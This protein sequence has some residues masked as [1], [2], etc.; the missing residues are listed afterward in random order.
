MTT[1]SL[2]TFQSRYGSGTSSK[3]RRTPKKV[4]SY[5]P[6]KKQLEVARKRIRE[7]LIRKNFTVLVE[8]F[9][10]AVAFCQKHVHNRG[11]QLGSRK[12]GEF[13]LV[14]TAALQELMANG[15]V[16]VDPDLGTMKLVQKPRR[17]RKRHYC[18]RPRYQRVA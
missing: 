2:E 10:D 18:A 4:A 15:V 1:M 7:A 14:V 9:D 3:T 13:K 8:S 17:Q 12:N 6:S 5:T 16:E 11:D